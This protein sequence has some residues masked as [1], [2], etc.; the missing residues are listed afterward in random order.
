MTMSQMG[1]NCQMAQQNLGAGCDRNCCRE[2]LQPGV[3]P[4]TAGAKPKVLATECVVAAVPMA[5]GQGPVFQAV[6]PCTLVRGAPARY[7]LFR[8]FRI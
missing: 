8:V 1:M 2:G 4:F 3:V 7:I 5:I 6:P